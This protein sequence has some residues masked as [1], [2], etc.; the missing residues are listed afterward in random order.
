MAD[1]RPKAE[2]ILEHLVKRADG[3][4]DVTAIAID[5]DGYADGRSVAYALRE[6]ETAGLI[7]RTSGRRR[8]LWYPTAR[9]REV[10]AILDRITVA[11]GGTFEGR[12]RA[13]ITTSE[14]LALR[15]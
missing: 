7:Q 1:G 13:G 10:D 3:A 5:V 11:R 9:G 2:R 12:V 15:A 14:T 6:L 4:Q 8:S